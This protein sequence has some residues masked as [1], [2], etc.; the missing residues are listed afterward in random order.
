MF[1]VTTIYFF[2]GLVQRSENVTFVET[3]QLWACLSVGKR[4][5]VRLT[6]CGN[7]I[8]VRLLISAWLRRASSF[9]RL[10]LC[11]SIILFSSS[12]VF[13]L[14]SMD[15][16]CF[17]TG[18]NNAFSSETTLPTM[19]SLWEGEINLKCYLPESGAASCLLLSSDW[20]HLAPLFRDPSAACLH[21]FRYLTDKRR[22]G[23]WTL[24]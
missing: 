15:E 10:S 18:G 20:I 22:T 17:Q 2:K 14:H 12:M 7:W 1:S 24:P 11:C 13:R 8:S 21:C 6:I 5:S 9:N 19:L 3:I 23:Q 4:F 16:I